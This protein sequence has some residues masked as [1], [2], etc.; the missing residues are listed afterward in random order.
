MIFSYIKL[1]SKNICSNTLINTLVLLKL[2]I[3]IIINF[4]YLVITIIYVVS[5]YLLTH[6]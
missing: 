2:N 4:I 3:K 6:K 5:L 1:K